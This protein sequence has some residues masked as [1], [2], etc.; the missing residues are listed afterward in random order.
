MIHHYKF[1][2]TSSHVTIIQRIRTKYFFIEK[3]N[4]WA[5]YQFFKISISDWIVQTKV[6]MSTIWLGCNIVI[7]VW[8]NIQCLWWDIWMNKSVNICLEIEYLF[9]F[10]LITPQ[11]ISIVSIWWFL[12]DSARKIARL[13]GIEFERMD[14]DWIKSLNLLWYQIFHL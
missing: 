12:S 8:M 6:I 14:Y 9:N 4:L 5:K 2:I 7:I 10:E 3:M 13:W 11:N 1:N